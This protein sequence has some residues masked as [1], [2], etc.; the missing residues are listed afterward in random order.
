MKDKEQLEKSK[1]KVIEEIKKQPIVKE[2]KTV[3]NEY[4][5][6]KIYFYLFLYLITFLIIFKNKLCKLLYLNFKECNIANK[7]IEEE[8]ILNCKELK[9][10]K[11]IKTIEIEKLIFIKK[12][13]N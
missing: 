2:N 8:K 4:I 13:E 3:I 9:E 10:D 5:K 6:N 7:E 12:S 11:I 1:E